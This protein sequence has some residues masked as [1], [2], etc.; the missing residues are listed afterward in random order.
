MIEA[1]ASNP[2]LK[3][4]SKDEV[5]EHNA[6]VALDPDFYLSNGVLNN[7][8]IIN[9][10]V[11]DFYNGLNLAATPPSI[12]NLVIIKRG[13]NKYS[14]YLIELKDVKK[15]SR[16]CNEQIKGK[17]STTINDFMLNKF[18]SEF[19][20]EH[21]KITDLNLWLVCNRFS[22]MNKTISDE[23]YEKRIKNTVIEKI[24]MIPP[25]KYKG[26]ISMITSMFNNV[27]IY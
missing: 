12:D 1:I 25:F 19:D 10:A 22:F 7:D 8:V 11:D 15:L 20:I 26:K 21:V 14:V 4:L 23:D 5:K 3:A 18:K 27:E 6:K 24:M 2:V 13:Q 17:F 9:L 16:I